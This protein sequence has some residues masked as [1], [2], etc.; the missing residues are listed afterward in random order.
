MHL[1]T[2][3]GQPYGSVR[4]CCERCGAA[5]R[6][7]ALGDRENGSE[8]WT[9]DVEAYGNLPVGYVQCGGAMPVVLAHP[10]SRRVD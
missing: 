3:R 5:T 7:W 2:Q 9:D 10:D 6:R 1:I 8:Q 4:R